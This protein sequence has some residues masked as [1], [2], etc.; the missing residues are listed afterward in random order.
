[1]RKLILAALV[2][3][4]CA[5]TDDAAVDTT[6]AIEPAAPAM[7]AAPAMYA[8]TWNG[9]SFST[10]A[11]DSGIPWTMTFNAG[12]DTGMTG[13]L[14][15]AAG[16]EDI[17][18]RVTE[19]S[20]STLRSEFGPYRSPTVGNAE[21]STTTEGRIA[22]DSLFGSFVATPTAGGDRFSGR[23]AARRGQ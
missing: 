17:P 19:A 3:V 4:A 2:L 5:K 23:F 21:V 8:G 11:A 22:G 9:R 14:R 10:A 13:T 7:T 20:E 16:T 12:P 18:I 15:F 6:A 1:M